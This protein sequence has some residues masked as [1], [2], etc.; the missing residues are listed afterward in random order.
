M[1][2]VFSMHGVGSVGADP[3]AATPVTVDHGM[4][5]PD[6]GATSVQTSAVDDVQLK[7]SSVSSPVAASHEVP[8]DDPNHGAAE[9]F[10]AVCLAVLL[11]GLMWLIASVRPRRSVRAAVCGMGARSRLDMALFRPPRPP[12]LSSLCLLRI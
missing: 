7:S 6:G 8:V 9:H 11:A 2:A 3:N 5:T 1:T 4:G 10:L 12:D